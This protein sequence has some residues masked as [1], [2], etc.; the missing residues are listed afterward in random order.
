MRTW[1]VI[2]LLVGCGSSPPPKPPPPRPKSVETEKAP[3]PAPPPA[4]K[5]P[6]IYHAKAAMTPTKAS[7]LEPFTIGFM[8]HEGDNALVL[9]DLPVGV[10]AGTYHYLIH[11]GAE[12]GPDGTKVGP[13]W[14]ETKDVDLK[15][16]VL[17]DLTGA[18]D[19]SELAAHLEGEQAIVKHTL[20]LHDDKK[21][22]PGK[23]LA[24]GTIEPSED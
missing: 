9:A 24:C 22:K 5:E 15:L 20:V 1:F 3:A 10:K 17:K 23:P 12:C 19:N 21:G 4:E 18:L 8:Q 14:R 6:V 11:E 2:T 7:R 13:V 16:V